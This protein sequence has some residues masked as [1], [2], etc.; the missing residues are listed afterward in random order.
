M[1]V[2]AGTDLGRWLRVFSSAYIPAGARSAEFLFGVS[3]SDGSQ[4]AL[5]DAAYLA[6]VP[7]GAGQDQGVR[8]AVDNLPGE[9][10]FG[11][12]ALRSPDLYADLTVNKPL[13]IT[14]DS[15]GAAT[16]NPVKIELW[17]DGPNGSQLLS[18][19]AASAPDT[20]RFAWTPSNSGLV[21]GTYGLRIKI[22]SVAH[23]QIYDIS[24]ETFTVPEAGSTPCSSAVSV[25]TVSASIVASPSMGRRT[26]F[27]GCSPPF[28]VRTRKR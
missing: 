27:R 22:S 13:F 23:P 19:I 24:T 10:S 9:S 15:Y 8:V 28:L 20:G 18:T 16:N 7:R 2:P 6:V 5:L 14:W 4:G 25:I 26:E 21:A 12:L 1:V 17:Q 3:K 11:R